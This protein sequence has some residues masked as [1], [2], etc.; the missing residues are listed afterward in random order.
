MYP[1]F[2]HLNDRKNTEVDQL[3]RQYSITDEGID[4]SVMNALF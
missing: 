4:K 1:L 2:N 3:R